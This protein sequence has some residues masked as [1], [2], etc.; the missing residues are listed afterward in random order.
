[1]SAANTAESADFRG[2]LDITRAATMVLDAESTVIGWSPA[3]AELLGYEPSEVLGRPLSAFLSA[4]PV[5]VG[6]ASSDGPPE[7]SPAPEPLDP[8]GPAEPLDPSGPSDPSDV[9][10]T[11]APGLGPSSLVPRRQRDPRG[12]H[13]RRP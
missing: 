12:A 7:P 3:A 13:P 10:G 8:S 1:M 5:T 11:A 2:P 9:A 6:G 4:H